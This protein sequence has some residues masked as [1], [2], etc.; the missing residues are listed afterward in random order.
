MADLP[1]SRIDVNCCAFRTGLSELRDVLWEHPPVRA[2]ADQA[3]RTLRPAEAGDA[4]G[5]DHRPGGC[6]GMRSGNDLSID[7]TG[8]LAPEGRTAAGKRVD[9]LCA[10]CGRPAARLRV[11]LAGNARGGLLGWPG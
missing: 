5:F 8:R 9:R 4:G 1:R 3:A 10:R 7:R 6:G 11:N 2:W